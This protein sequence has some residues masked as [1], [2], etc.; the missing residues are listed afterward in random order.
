MMASVVKEEDITYEDVFNILQESR[1]LIA[2]NKELKKKSRE[3]QE[4]TAKL[5]LTNVKLKKMDRLKDEFISTV[6]H[7]MRTP[8]TSIR[9]FSEILYDNTSLDDEQKAHFLS[10]IIKETER[11]DRLI[12]Q[13]LE[14]ERFES[15][16]QKLNMKNTPMNQV[17]HDAIDTLSQVAKEKQ[18]IFQADLQKDIPPVMAD[19]DR[20]MQVMLNLLSNA[21]KFC[22]QTQGRIVISSYYLDGDVK[23][24]VVDNGKGIPQEDLPL[25]FEGFF[26]A[27][28]QN[29]KKPKGSGLGLTISKKIIEHHQGAIWVE[30]ENGRGAKFSFTLP[31][32]K[33]DAVKINY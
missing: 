27:S 8:I 2:A 12:T 18:V 13:V 28:N 19:P 33:R 21:I 14:L 6:T 10:T 30:N 4:A 26:Q 22:D 1:E 31:I 11:M 7:E 16:K 24:N 32:Y 3:L 15:G 5:K 9:A 25:I 17:I 20:L 29:F 23:V